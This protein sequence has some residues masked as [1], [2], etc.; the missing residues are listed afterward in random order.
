MPPRHA[1]SARRRL[2]L[3]YSLAAAAVVAAAVVAVSGRRSEQKPYAPGEA[4]EGITSELARHLPADHP[5]ISFTNVAPA[6]GIHFRH[7]PGTRSTQLPEDM[8]S[9]LAWGDYDGD[10]D[11]D[12]F[13]CNIAAPLTASPEQVAASPGTNVLYR[14]NGD[15]TFTDVT[16]Q[17][18]LEHRGIGMAAA[19]ADYDNDGDEDLVVTTYQRILLYRNRGDGTFEEV[20]RKAGLAGLKRYW[21]GASWGDYN[22]DGFPDLYVC[23]YVDYQYRPEDV[24]KVSRQ[25][26]TVVPFT[27]NPSSYAPQPNALFRN[28]GDGTFTE[29][30]ER[31]GVANETGRSLTVSWCD[32][33][34][35]G[36]IDLY[37]ANDVSDNAMYR[38]LGNGR[39]EDVSHSALVSDYRG[40]M[41][42]AV[43]D[44]DNDT[45]ADLFI[46]HWMAQENALFW[47][48]FRAFGDEAAGKLQFMDIADMM[49]L[50]QQALDRI[51]WATSFFDFDNDGRLDLFVVNG[52]TFQREDDPTHLVPMADF[53]FWQKNPQDGFFDL[54]RVAGPAFTELHVGRGG[55]YADYDGDGDLDLAILEYGEGL[56]LLRNEGGNRRHWIKVRLRGSRSGRDAFGAVVELTAGGRTQTRFHGAQPS[57]LSQDAPEIHFGLG[58]AAQAERIV[59][60]FPSGKVREFTNVPAGKTLIVEE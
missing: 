29:V 51:G 25:F 12:L 28:N 8:G 52:S 15:G 45:D 44:Y 35:D 7:F 60:R 13:V 21:A 47:N 39:F 10:G 26:E 55:A 4:V 5:R 9:G 50:G 34:L 40:A 27:L 11:F 36:W 46:T 16:A 38:N 3:K 37:I 57:Y 20:S 42:L 19:W 48:M 18:G 43:G 23:A 2:I 49:G 30:A 54:S 58:D 24:G 31:A 33:D 22:H 56:Y 53:L 14:N 59:V 32:F 1:L 6:A 17:A 41:G